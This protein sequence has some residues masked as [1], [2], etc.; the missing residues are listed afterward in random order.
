VDEIVLV[1]DAEPDRVVSVSFASAVHGHKDSP[2]FRQQLRA[3]LQDEIA[4][5]AA[6]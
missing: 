1:S 2:E 4:A 5:T 3:M 6:P